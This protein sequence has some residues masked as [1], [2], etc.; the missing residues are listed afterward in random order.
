M[1]CSSQ[2]ARTP[3]EVARR[4]REDARGARDR[5]EEDRRDRLRALGL[6]GAAQVG[7]RALA[8]LLLGRRVELRAVEERPEE[9]HGTGGRGVVGEAARVA[10][11]VDRGLGAAVIAA[12]GRQHLEAPGLQPRHAYGV[13]VGVGA[14]VGEEHLREAVGRDLADQLRGLGPLLVGHGRRDRAQ[15]VGLLLDRG[16]HARV[17]V[18]DVGED[19]LRGEVEVAAVLVV[20]HVGAAGRGDHHRGDLGLGGPGVEDVLAVQLS[21]G[22]HDRVLSVVLLSGSSG[23]PARGHRWSPGR[24]TAS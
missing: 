22:G 9:V 4:R 13:L 11:Q 10:G 7:E 24:A 17:L 19:Q 15:P 21:G 1:P 18:A 20:P 12:V 3:G 6:D 8:L 14:A 2:S 5:L 16:D 23:R